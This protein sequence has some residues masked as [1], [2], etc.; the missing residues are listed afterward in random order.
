M[1]RQR[2]RRYNLLMRF[3]AL[4]FLL[5]LATAVFAEDA[6]EAPQ[7]D[8]KSVTVPITLDHDRIVIDADLPLADGS[9]QQVRAWVDPGNPNFEM[10][11]RVATV[12]G[13]NVKCDS[14]ACS[15]PPP[16]AIAIG[17][18]K[19]SLAV[20]K[21]AKIP[22][23]DAA[24]SVM[25]PGMKAEINIPSRVLR[26]Y[27]VLIDFP[28][29]EITIAQPGSMKFNG[30]K[31]KVAMNAEN[32]LIDVP[33]QI[34]NKKYN[35]GLDLGSPI[36][37]LAHDLFDKLS[38]AH[39]DWPRMTGAIGPANVSGSSE[40]MKQN[41]MRVDRLQYGP[42][43]LTEV[44]VAELSTSQTKLS[45]TA[46]AKTSAGT[47]GSEALLNYRVGLDYAHSSVYFEIGRTFTFPDFDVIGLM[48]RP[49]EDGGFTVAGIADYEGE[50]SVPGG[51]NGVQNGDGLI[52]VDGVQTAGSTL[53]QVWSMLGGEAGKERRLTVE[54]AGRQFA[55]IAKVQHFL[56]ETEDS[57]PKNSKRKK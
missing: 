35:L 20:V 43:F 38:A 42:L 45:E 52:A 5:I 53:G 50:P 36:S 56:G 9:V 22:L 49:E 29:H 6:A 18:M 15:A 55:V 57:S 30:V 33:S 16:G 47:L 26:H 34:E 17:G 7:A 23:S 28:G 10:S 54:R 37:F 19:I 11:R 27:D 39:P 21:D 32:G 3:T 2:T 25:T 40:E 41:L 14:Q 44:A 4:L 8:V 13:F 48:L 51:Q 46:G 12:M 24:A 1:L 31:T